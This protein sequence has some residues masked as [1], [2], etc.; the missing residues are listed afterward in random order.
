[1]VNG[2]YDE[3]ISDWAKG[4]CTRAAPEDAGFC[5]AASA[6]GLLEVSPGAKQMALLIG[7]GIVLAPM[8]AECL[9]S[10]L[11]PRI[12]GGAADA[13]SPEGAALASAAGGTGAGRLLDDILDTGRAGGRK[14]VGTF[15]QPNAR[16]GDLRGL[17]AGNPLEEASI[18]S[19][20]EMSDEQLIAAVRAP[21]DGGYVGVN[22]KREVIINGIT[23]FKSCCDDLA[24]RRILLLPTICQYS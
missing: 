14:A 15:G 21:L 22:G 23:E 19:V 4:I 20:R 16:L 13:I 7:V 8:I 6:Y 10:T 2:T 5:S 1:M 9:A 3:A 11:C 17:E 18:R 24:I 12:V